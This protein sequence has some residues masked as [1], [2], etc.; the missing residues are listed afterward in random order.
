MR[1]YSPNAYPRPRREWTMERLI[2]SF[3]S[4]RINRRIDT[5]CKTML[6]SSQSNYA[7]WL[8]NLWF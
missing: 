3:W 5:H 1:A 6:I 8:D 7:V 4:G 2:L